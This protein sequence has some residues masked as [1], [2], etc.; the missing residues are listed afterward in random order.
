MTLD[1]PLWVPVLCLG[2]GIL[3]V[4]RAAFLV[5]GK[6]D[7][8]F[9]GDEWTSMAIGFSLLLLGQYLLSR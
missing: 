3:L 9:R 7:G 6:G 8:R 2:S 1:L 5:A 4:L